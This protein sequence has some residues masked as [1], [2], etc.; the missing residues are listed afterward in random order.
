MSTTTFDS[1]LLDYIKEETKKVLQE[2]EEPS[3][4]DFFGKDAKEKAKQLKSKLDTA[5]DK[6]VARKKRVELIKKS[7]ELEAKAKKLEKH[8]SVLKA[9]D[10]MPQRIGTNEKELEK[11]KQQ[12]V[13]LDKE[14]RKLSTPESERIGSELGKYLGDKVDKFIEQPKK[15]S[16]WL[17]YK[18]RQAKALGKPQT[19]AGMEQ[20]TRAAQQMV[21][22]HGYGEMLGKYG[23]DGKYGK[24]TFNAIK[25][26]QKDLG[27]KVP[28]GIVG[29]N[30]IKAFNAKR[31]ERV[32]F[33]T[34]EQ[35]G[36]KFVAQQ[37]A[38]QMQKESKVSKTMLEKYIAQNT[39]S[40]TKTIIKEEL[41]KLLNE[42]NPMYSSLIGGPDLSSP[43]VQRQLTGDA[44]SKAIKKAAEIAS[45]IKNPQASNSFLKRLW[46][47]VKDAFKKIGE[48][49][50]SGLKQ[51]FFSSGPKVAADVAVQGGR[52]ATWTG[53]AGQ[54]AAM[55]WTSVTT[56]FSWL[57]GI[58]AAGGLAAIATAV[59]A[60]IAIGA[61]VMAIIL[62][63]DDG[64]GGVAKATLEGAGL[65]SS[66]QA[67]E[68]NQLMK[69]AFVKKK[70]SS[71]FDFDLSS[72]GD[73]YSAI[74]KMRGKSKK[75]IFA[76]MKRRLS[77][78][79]YKRAVEL[80]KEIG[81][82]QRNRRFEQAYARLKDQNKS[83]SPQQIGALAGATA[84][85]D[86]YG[87]EV[88]GKKPK[89]IPG[90]GGSSKAA[91]QRKLAQ[92]LGMTIKDIQ[93][94]LMN[95]FK[96]GS[97]TFSLEENKGTVGEPDGK[98]GGETEQ[99]IKD[100]QNE[101][102]G[103]VAAKKI[104]AKKLTPD[105]LFGPATLAAVKMVENDK[106]LYALSRLNPKNSN[107]GTMVAGRGPQGLPGGNK[108]AEKDV[109]QAEVDKVAQKIATDVGKVTGQKVSP[110]DVKKNDTWGEEAWIRPNLAKISS[111]NKTIEDWENSE[112]WKKAIEDLKK[113]G[114]TKTTKE[115]TSKNFMGIP[116]GQEEDFNR[117]AAWAGSMDEQK[118][119]RGKTTMNKT[120]LINIIKEEIESVLSEQFRY[121]EPQISRDE[122]IYQLQ[123]ELAD[124]HDRIR[125]KNL[126]YLNQKRD[127][128]RYKGYA[129]GRRGMKDPVAMEWQKALEF[130]KG[131]KEFQGGD[132]MRQSFWASVQRKTGSLEIPDL[133]TG[134]PSGQ[135]S[136]KAT[137]GRPAV[138]HERIGKINKGK[139]PN[140]LPDQSQDLAQGIKGMVADPAIQAEIEAKRKKQRRLTSPNAL[141]RVQRKLIQLK[142]LPAKIKNSAQD[143]GSYGFNTMQAI[144]NFQ[145]WANRYK[146]NL[147]PGKPDGLAGRKTLAALRAT[148]LDQV[149][150]SQ[151]AKKMRSTGEL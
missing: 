146:P 3:I 15:A 43:A 68:L 54:L 149:L 100:F 2:Q 105:G 62:Y 17:P 108:K 11:M 26:M 72:D 77:A 37:A 36:E 82:I 24:N 89:P 5:A 133:V 80:D 34:A 102:N 88:A 117:A 32:S 103:Y 48:K 18:K 143:D 28:D 65:D 31:N 47:L 13:S 101:F 50:P 87:G 85:S 92:G 52:I 148:T 135:Q 21:I 131:T 40:Q 45:K 98:Y 19:P 123:P 33:D 122:K 137:A 44:G 56:F 70:E 46:N 12:L 104:K 55:A 22:K 10:A 58:L 106:E 150:T 141:R 51:R 138:G 95:Y 97:N 113:M 49:I 79:D 1:E 30:T 35:E 115:K 78:A 93:K 38:R 136:A 25:A 86:Q 64:V 20:A 120:K 140:N 29:K 27:F 116:D 134:E 53:R 130:I 61:V 118:S 41:E 76:E 39:N 6:Q 75:D 4:L 66:E 60:A 73:D 57:G 111:M 144:K 109:S 23:A 110:E 91:K 126:D 81:D 132:D 114:I 16:P 121:D 145:L 119:K 71:F 14:I 139:I 90:G 142:F 84:G 63:F 128:G 112:E 125:K 151:V 7:Q 67:E 147:E 99:A 42:F 8:I 129:I 94:K 96:K 83:L 124:A 9:N 107:S 74:R 59:L 127:P 69:K